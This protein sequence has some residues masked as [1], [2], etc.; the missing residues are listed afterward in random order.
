MEAS[1]DANA[2]NSHGRA[3]LH[4]LVEKKAVDKEEKLKK[5]SLLV[6]LL[7]YGDVDIDKAT[8]AGETA[9]HIATRV[10]W[11]MATY[12]FSKVNTWPTH[13]IVLLKTSLSW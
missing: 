2:L 4:S 11:R 1:T 9:L 7:T 8:S 10:S 5:M 12:E 6:T 3:P 13:F